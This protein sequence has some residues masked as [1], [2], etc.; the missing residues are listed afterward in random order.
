VPILDDPQDRVGRASKALAHY[1][2][3]QRSD[4]D[5]EDTI[6]DLITDLM[7]YA[8]TLGLKGRVAASSA[9][10]HYLAENGP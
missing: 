6:V 1:R 8:D 3:V 10:S 4:S 9:L 7:L 5:V 2:V